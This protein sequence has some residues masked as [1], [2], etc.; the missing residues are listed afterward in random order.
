M[1]KDL[2]AAGLTAGTATSLSTA[3]RTAASSV[4]N[5]L[6]SV[7]PAAVG[8]A[9]E[10]VDGLSLSAADESKVYETLVESAIAQIN[11]IESLSDSS[12]RSAEFSPSELN[13]LLEAVIE[14]IIAKAPDAAAIK[15]ATKGMAKG[16]GKVGLSTEELT[17]N[18]TGALA[19]ISVTFVLKIADSDRED[20]DKVAAVQG[21][22]EGLTAGV[23]AIEAIIDKT[24]SVDSVKSNVEGMQLIALKIPT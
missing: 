1:E 24:A 4:D 11:G 9:I 6:A 12:A 2:L 22:S 21:A 7:I 23:Y 10:A 5:D 20:L 3:A 14:V 16:V 19:K 13:T 15:S 18:E 8:G 17:N